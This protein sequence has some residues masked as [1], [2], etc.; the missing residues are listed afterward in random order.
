MAALVST[1]IL[2]QLVSTLPC[3]CTKCTTSIESSPPTFLASLRSLSDSTLSSS[4]TARFARALVRLDNVEGDGDNLH[5]DDLTPLIPHPGRDTMLERYITAAKGDLDKARHLLTATLVWRHAYCQG[6]GTLVLRRDRSRVVDQYYPLGL[7]GKGKIRDKEGRPIWI[8]R[9]GLSDCNVV[10]TEGTVFQGET[11]EET[12][13]RTHVKKYFEALSL[14]SERILIMDMEELTTS[15]VSSTVALGLIQSMANVDQRHFPGTLH[16]LTVINAPWLF[17]QVYGLV[18]SWL[19]P[20]TASLFKVLGDPLV[21]EEV[22]QELLTDI[23]EEDLPLRYGGTLSNSMLPPL[24][25]RLRRGDK[26]I[27]GEKMF[28]IN[29]GETVEVTV[30]L[31]GWWEDRA[32]RM[33]T[34]SGGSGTGAGAGTDTGTGTGTGSDQSAVVALP[35]LI[36]RS[37]G[38]N[39][40]VEAQLVKRLSEDVD[41]PLPLLP[42]VTLECQNDVI[43]REMF[44]RS[45]NEGGGEDFMSFV[46]I[47]L[48]FDHSAMW[49]QR[50]IFCELEGLVWPLS[51]CL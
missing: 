44:V 1:D 7:L 13:I 35:A 27:D 10:T 33:S 42:R 47:V 18:S 32:R 5:H 25:W 11:L 36:I 17:Q 34:E 15:H 39:V 51:K 41:V 6:M 30:P 8:E 46:A 45:D 3:T 31:S 48:K 14:H 26:K 9:V 24:H 19:A 38:F 4:S 20:E 28:V 29:S 2:D 40:Q 50:T 16:K 21:D 37:L 49:R 43:R 12:F 23:R 22:R